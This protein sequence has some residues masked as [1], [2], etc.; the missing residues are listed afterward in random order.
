MTAAATDPELID[1]AVADDAEQPA[2]ELAAFGLEGFGPAPE[3]DEN[4]LG[5]VFGKLGIGQDS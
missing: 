4:I 1:G 3:P 2:E 5:R